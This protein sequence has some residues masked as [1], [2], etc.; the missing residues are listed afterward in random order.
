MAYYINRHIS[1][2]LERWAMRPDHRPLI[3]RGARQV[4]KTTAVMQFAS[5]FDCFLHLN[6]ERESHRRLFE[7]TD[8]VRQLIENIHLLLRHKKT[9]GKT[10]IFIDEIQNSPRA[11]A[12]LRYF[13]EDAPET[14][15]IAAGSLLESLIDV[16]VSFPVGR[17]EYLAV[18]PCSFLE[19]LDGL[20]ETFDA[21]II[22]EVKADAVHERLMQSFRSYSVVGGMPAA[23]IRYSQRRDLLDL[24]DIF[25]SLITSY[26]ED[27][28]KY[29]KN[30]SQ[31]RILSHILTYGWACA[32]ETISFERFAGSP[33]KSREIGEALR[34][35]ERAMLVELAYPVTEPRLPLIANMNRHPKLLWFDTGLVNFQAGIRDVRLTKTATSDIWRGRIGEQIVGQELVAYNH[36]ILSRRQF[37]SRDKRDGNAEVD[38]VV[39]HDDIIVPIEVKTGHNSKLKSLHYFMDNV[40]HDIAVRVWDQPFSVDI[41]STLQGKSFKLINIPFYYVSQLRNIL[42]NYR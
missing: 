22:K 32:G 10:L 1:S 3:L 35:L 12:M 7:E 14:Y 5:Q 8:D 34:T 18:R 36:D 30:E 15:V 24:D 9:G 38:F 25:S 28:E 6:L 33:Y 11:I 27:S 29:A 4:G 2:E 21:A 26:R 20:G 16:H 40:S 39:R 19:F 41:V 23:I 31:R 13:Y 42:T 37:W 17:V